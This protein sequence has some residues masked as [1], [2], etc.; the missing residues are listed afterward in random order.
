MNLCHAI[1]RRELRIVAALGQKGASYVLRALEPNGGSRIQG[2]FPTMPP[3]RQILNA[4]ASILEMAR[5]ESSF[6]W[7]ERQWTPS[8]SQIVARCKQ[9]ESASRCERLPNQR[10]ILKT[11]SS[12]RNRCRRKRKV[13]PNIR[14][15]IRGRFWA[16]GISVEK[17]GSDINNE[18]RQSL[19]KRPLV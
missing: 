15:R 9:L 6:A 17:A 14:R 3:C 12:I 2:K 8:N 11:Q 18:C 4:L 19:N 7:M 10:A 16:V 5:G 1:P 13:R